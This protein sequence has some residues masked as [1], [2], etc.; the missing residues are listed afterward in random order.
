MPATAPRRPV[1]GSIFSFNYVFTTAIP[2]CAHATGLMQARLSG[3]VQVLIFNTAAD[4]LLSTLKAV[5]FSETEG[6]PHIP[7][8]GPSVANH[9]V[10]IATL[11][12]LNLLK[13]LKA[14]SGLKYDWR[15]RVHGDDVTYGKLYRC[16]PAWF[17]RSEQPGTLVYLLLSPWF[18]FESLLVSEAGRPPPRS[19]SHIG[20]VD[21]RRRECHAISMSVVVKRPGC[22][23][24]VDAAGVGP[25]LS[26][27]KA[28]QG[29]EDDRRGEEGRGR[30]GES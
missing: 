26:G 1:F 22:C 15:C 13:C 29:G 12:F 3:Q 7:L 21:G 8:P 17:R 25:K 20:R 5:D 11:P 28:L 19:T 16:G 4:K 18:C 10:H 2:S 24:D 27:R 23:R 9:P 14:R 6:R 30:R